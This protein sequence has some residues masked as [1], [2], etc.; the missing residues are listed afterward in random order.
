MAEPGALGRQAAVRLTHVLAWPP[1]VLQGARQDA[2]RR[3][4]TF[5]KY[6]VELVQAHLAEQR[7][8]QGF[9]ADPGSSC[10]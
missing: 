9:R 7:A 2:T 4:V 5:E 8:L 3:G 10:P 1:L 6:L